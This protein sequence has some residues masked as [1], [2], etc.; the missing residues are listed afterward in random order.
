R[1]LSVPVKKKEPVTPEVIQRL[2]AYY[3]SSPASLS[4]LRVLTLCILDYARFFRIKD[5]TGVHWEGAWVVIA[6]T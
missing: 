5:K 4:D 1:L 6:K 3:G 2:F